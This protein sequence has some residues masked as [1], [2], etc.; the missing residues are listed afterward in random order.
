MV[1]GCDMYLLV[2]QPLLLG[3]TAL[4]GPGS[5]RAGRGQV[6]GGGGRGHILRV[7]GVVWGAGR[8]AR[9]RGGR[10][11]LG[12]GA[13]LVGWL[14][15]MK[16]A[17]RCSHV[18][19]GQVARWRSWG[20]VVA[21]R[22]SWGQ[23]VARCSWGL[24]ASHGRLWEGKRASQYHAGKLSDMSKLLSELYWASQSVAHVLSM[25]VFFFFFFFLQR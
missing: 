12:R 6:L 13:V 1:S 11:S 22:R 19:P 16:A 10:A 15:V 9:G 3:G 5:R 24:H 14:Q 2:G 8:R 21:K 18:I 23:V 7:V 4:G 20:Q 25:T 17:R